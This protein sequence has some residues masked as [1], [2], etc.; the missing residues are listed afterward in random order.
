MSQTSDTATQARALS[1][2]R[3]VI[4]TVEKVNEGGLLS[5]KVWHNYGRIFKGAPLALDA[6]GSRVELTEVYSEKNDQWYVASLRVLSKDESTATTVA[7]EVQEADAST[8]DRS[9]EA[10]ALISNPDDR[11]A[12]PEALVYA[13]DLALKA[14]ISSANLETIVELRFGKA[15]GSLTVREASKT[16]EF[17]GGYRRAGTSVFSKRS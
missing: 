15:F 4:V 10:P 16:I 6:V 7:P 5:E 14:G 12:K 2:R 17:L 9:A 8:E 3:T 13:E 11:P 1:P